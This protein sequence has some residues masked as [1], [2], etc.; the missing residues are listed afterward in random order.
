MTGAWEKDVHLVGV[1]HCSK[2]SH[3]SY[4]LLADTL[5]KECRHRDSTVLRKGGNF[6]SSY[7]GGF[8]QLIK[9]RCGDLMF[10]GVFKN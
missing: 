1:A 6:C 9:V 10:E 4:Y 2:I 3:L 8:G 7:W 5:A